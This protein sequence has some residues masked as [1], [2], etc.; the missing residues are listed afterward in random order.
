MSRVPFRTAMPQS[1]QPRLVDVEE[2]AAW[3]NPL[4]ELASWSDGALDRRNDRRRLR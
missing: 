4:L 3:M 1:I 2:V